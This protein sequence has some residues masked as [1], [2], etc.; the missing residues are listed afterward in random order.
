MKKPGSV[1]E[2]LVFELAGCRYGLPLE[3]V[4]EVVR[5]VE[6]TAFPGAPAVVKGLINVRGTVQPVFDVLRRFGHEPKPV[7]PEDHFVLA[8]TMEREVVLHVHQVWELIEIDA[9]HLED[10]EGVVVE[11]R[12]VAGVA[13]LPDGLMVIHDLEVFLTNVEAATLDAAMSDVTGTEPGA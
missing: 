1:M 12:L 3:A 8:L 7:E 2:V 10:L 9:G 5:A 4:R 13:K 11:S 6:V